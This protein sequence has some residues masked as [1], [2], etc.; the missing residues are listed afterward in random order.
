[1]ATALRRPVSWVSGVESGGRNGWDLRSM[2]KSERLS[3]L[4][5]T[6]PGQRQSP[7]TSQVSTEEPGLLTS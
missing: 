6:H 7:C 2:K 4:Y 3:T 1:M 5:R